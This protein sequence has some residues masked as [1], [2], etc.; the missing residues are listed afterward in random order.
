ML[1][2]IFQRSANALLERVTQEDG[3]LFLHH[4]VFNVLKTSQYATKL[5]TL[6]YSPRLYVLRSDLQSHGIAVE[7][8]IEGVQPIDYSGFVALTREYPSV[9]SWT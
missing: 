2:L 7:R 8:L 1:H 3:L 4:A 9:C 6:P 5:A